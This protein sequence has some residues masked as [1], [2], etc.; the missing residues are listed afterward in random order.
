MNGEVSHLRFS[1][2]QSCFFWVQ[3]VQSHLSSWPTDIFP[4]RWNPP[5]RSSTQAES[6]HSKCFKIA[7]WPH[8][9]GGA[10]TLWVQSYSISL[11]GIVRIHKCSTETWKPLWL[12]KTHNALCCFCELLTAWAGPQQQAALRSRQRGRILDI[13]PWW[14]PC[15]YSLVCAVCISSVWIS[16]GNIKSDLDDKYFPALSIS[17]DSTQCSQTKKKQN[18]TKNFQSLSR[19]I[20]DMLDV[21]LFFWDL[22]NEFSRIK[23][24]WSSYKWST[25][26]IFITVM[27]PIQFSDLESFFRRTG[28]P[29]V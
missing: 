22:L 10:H 20:W 29:A 11:L 27:N 13:S 26:N 8:H 17:A 18:K 1:N 24:G 19:N 21:N 28:S 15:Y 16:C 6:E 14:Q 3:L 2:D 5:T 12:V 7:A 9:R 23:K 4:M 25:D